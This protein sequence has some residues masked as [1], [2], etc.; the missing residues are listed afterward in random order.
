MHRK[1]GNFSIERNFKNVQ[2]IVKGTEHFENKLYGN[3]R[4]TA[5]AVFLSNLSI[6]DKNERESTAFMVLQ[7]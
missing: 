7:I 4:S 3:S 1:K 6:F 5:V 2:P